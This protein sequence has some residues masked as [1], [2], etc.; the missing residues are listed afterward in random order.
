MK[1]WVK[2]RS[3][4]W[5]SSGFCQAGRDSIVLR[6]PLRPLVTPVAEGEG[7]DEEAGDDR[8][9][10]ADEQFGKEDGVDE[11]NFEEAT[12]QIVMRDRGQPAQSEHEERE[13]AHLPHRPWCQHCCKGR[14][15]H[16]QHRS[17]IRQYPPEEIS[18]FVQHTA[19]FR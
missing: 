14:M 17:L 5:M 4:A 9:V 18:M 16:H 1:S 3:D 8:E 19:Q 10:I 7:G 11:E 6:D 15:Q 2:A 13:A 12:K